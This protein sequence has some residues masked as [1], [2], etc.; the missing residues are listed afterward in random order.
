MNTA[1]LMPIEDKFKPFR[2]CFALQI[3]S[4]S[5]RSNILMTTFFDPALDFT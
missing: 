4:P 2:F 3:L 1:E 5:L